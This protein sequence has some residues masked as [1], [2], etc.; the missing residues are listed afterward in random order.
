M[1]RR[2]SGDGS[3]QIRFEA[4]GEIHP[5]GMRTQ[6]VDADSQFFGHL[7]KAGIPVLHQP[8]C[9]APEHVIVSR[10]GVFLFAFY[11]LK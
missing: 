9:A 7:S 4:S 6:R 5:R 8:H 1:K 10:G 2:Q 11:R 3:T